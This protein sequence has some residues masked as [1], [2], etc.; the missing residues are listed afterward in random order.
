VSIS[1]G[2]ATIAAGSAYSATLT[3]DEGYTVGEV[4]VTMGGVPVT[5]TNGVINIASVT[6]NIAIVATA[7]AESVGGEGS[8]ES[9]TPFDLTGKVNGGITDYLYCFG[10]E[11][12][13]IG[14]NKRYTLNFY[15]AAKTLIVSEYVMT[16][17]CAV[18]T[19]AIYLTIAEISAQYWPLDENTAI[20]PVVV[21]KNFTA[22]ENAITWVSGS[23]NL[24]TGEIETS[25]NLVSN[26]IAIGG[27]T[28]ADKTASVTAFYDKDKK[29][30]WVKQNYELS[31]LPACASYM[32]VQVFASNKY[33]TI[34]LA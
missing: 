18:P 10:A 1:N 31:A 9:G 11:Y 22:G 17:Y 29:L 27:A 34:T 5:V 12:I 21:D 2:A 19:N 28:S 16:E 3:A 32:R 26:Y 30:L 25:S 15:D 33:D 14:V 20:I 6:G 24:T 8:W 13:V 23:I 7:E 4:S